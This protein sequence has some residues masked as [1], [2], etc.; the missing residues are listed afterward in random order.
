MSGPINN[1]VDVTNYILIGVPAQPLHAFD[2]DKLPEKAIH[3]RRATE[4][5]TLVTLDGEE[6]TLENEI[7]I[8]SGGKP[9]ALAGV[10]GGLDTEISDE[11]TT[12]LLEA[13]LFDPKAV[14]L[15]SQKHNLRSESSARF[16]KGINKATIVQAGKRA[17]AL[18][19]ELGG[20]TVKE[21]FASAQS[22]D[23]ELPVV[24]ITL[25]R[26][27]HVLGTSFNTR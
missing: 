2:Y 26:L 24:S 17:A 4:D 20:G 16:E 25:E 5:E 19:A 6:R 15:A 10:M 11:T 12:V 23:L 1:L 9:V 14:R 8:T 18:I 21:A 7:V 22:Y 27:N 3:V 13:A